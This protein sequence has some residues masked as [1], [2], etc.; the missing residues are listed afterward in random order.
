MI[1][2]LCDLKLYNCLKKKTNLSVKL[3]N[4]DSYAVQPIDQIANNQE[5]YII[6]YW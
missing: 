5:K 1:N 4:K 3:L 2:T 6:S